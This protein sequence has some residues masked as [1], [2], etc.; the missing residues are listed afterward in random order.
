MWRKMDARGVFVV[1][2][3]AA[4]VFKLLLAWHLP[5]FVDEAF[6][7]Q[8][9]RHLAWAYSDVPGLTA[10]LIRLGEAVF[11]HSAFGI[12]VPFVLLA[13]M[14]PWLVVRI[15]AETV[16]ARAGW[17]AG[18]AA[19]LLPLGAT[20]GVLALPDVPMTL[21]AALCL[22]ACTRL[23]RRVDGGAVCWRDVVWLALGLV[24]GA[25][26]HYRFAAVIGVGCVAL[27]W[28]PHGRALLRAPGMWLALV[29]GALAWLPLV[30]WNWNHAEAGL[31]FQ[32]LERHPWAWHADGGLFVPMQALF[33]TPLLLLALLLAGWQNRRVG[34]AARRFLALCGL[35]LV[36]GFFALGFFADGERISFHWPLPGYLALLPLLPPLLAHWRRTWARLLWMLA[37]LGTAALFGYALAMLQPGF[38]ELPALSKWYP[39]NFSGWGEL[40]AVVRE[41]HAQMPDGTRIVADNFKTG[42]ELGFLLAD[43]DL[44]VLDHPLNHHHGR[45]PQ[46]HLWG[47]EFTHAHAV[48]GGP[49]LLV[50]NSTD[51]KFHALLEYYQGLCRT[52]GALPAPARVLELDGGHKRYVLFALTGAAA[53]DSTPCV[54]PVVAHVYF[55]EPGARVAARFEVVGWAVREGS[56]LDRVAVTLDDV[57]VASTRAWQPDVWL[58]EDFLRNA[59]RDPRIPEVKFTLDVDASALPPG[60]YRLGLRLTAPDGSVET[61]GRQWLEIQ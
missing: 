19:L 6:Y 4:V 1:L 42:A 47:L 54:T 16:G 20:L 10:W 2:W 61:W 7:W 18:C 15:A 51:V 37:A 44:A 36:A 29:A 53:R 46:L 9:G 35:G 45:A 43:A 22:L 56:G 8:E 13:C 23:L 21:A 60:R 25:L 38:R 58:A 55:P 41:V 39:G 27:V 40:A 30:W 3:I 11:G 49:V 48:A 28:L 57:E 5:L 34:D 17:I 50:V 31:R 26:S 24:L 59:S 14:L 32:L 52:F 12:R 33:V